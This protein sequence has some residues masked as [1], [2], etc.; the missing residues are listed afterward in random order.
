MTDVASLAGRDD[1][2]P[3]SDAYLPHLANLW[4]EARAA[5]APLLP[6]AIPYGLNPVGV[7]FNGRSVPP[8][9]G[10]ERVY[11]VFWDPKLG[12]QASFLDNYRAVIALAL[13]RVGADNVNTGDGALL[14][15]A[16]DELLRSTAGLG[17]TEKI[18]MDAGPYAPRAKFPAVFSYPKQGAVIFADALTVPAS[19]RE[20]VLGHLFLDFMMLPDVA[21]QN[22]SW[23]GIAQPVTGAHFEANWGSDETTLLT[24]TEFAAG[25]P[26]LPLTSDV[27]RAWQAIWAEVRPVLAARST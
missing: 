26:V 17:P 25:H 16:R 5:F 12:R 24:E 11:D 13:L 2:L 21:S 10:R 6:H 27:D 7:T 4:P 1:I 9:F 8:A 18:T 19:S 3:L 15:Q 22:E 23:V 14:H 20:P